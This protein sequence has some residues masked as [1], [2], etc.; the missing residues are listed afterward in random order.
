MTT[1]LL[2]TYVLVWPVIVA[3]TL[4]Y[5]TKSFWTEWREARARGERI[6]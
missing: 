4:I 6:V 2:T 1:I 3:G 5:I